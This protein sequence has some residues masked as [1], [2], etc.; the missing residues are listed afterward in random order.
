MSL[1]PD[2]LTQHYLQQDTTAYDSGIWNLK[3]FIQD[4]F[5]H[6]YLL[7][8]QNFYLLAMTSPNLIVLG[9]HM[10]LEEVIAFYNTFVSLASNTSLQK[11][12]KQ[13]VGAIPHAS[14]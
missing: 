9:R 13:R 11:A 6:F 8:S 3:T 14:L 7:R 5:V 2:P 10:T 12:L 1:T 4:K